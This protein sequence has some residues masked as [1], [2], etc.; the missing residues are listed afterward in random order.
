MLKK[1]V[2]FLD[3]FSDRRLYKKIG[4]ALNSADG[5]INVR[6]DELEFIWNNLR[7]LHSK[8]GDSKK[9]L[10]R[11]VM[12][13]HYT[14][15]DLFAVTTRLTN[16]VTDGTELPARDFAIVPKETSYDDWFYDNREYRI[17]PVETLD[18]LDGLL[19]AFFQAHD[20]SLESEKIHIYEYR[21][22]IA[23]PMMSD[24][25]SLCEVLYAELNELAVKSTAKIG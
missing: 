12:K 9:V 11:Y 1:V 19:G 20:V 15:Q 24:I 4:H 3:E 17:D 16:S 7:Y 21:V 22:S 25:Y 10:R 6:V 18:E 14:P 2:R 8:R 13:M 5:S 23:Y